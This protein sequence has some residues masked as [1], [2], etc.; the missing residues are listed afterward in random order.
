MEKSSDC[1]NYGLHAAG[2]S[3]SNQGQYKFRTIYHGRNTRIGTRY[4]LRRWDK[5]P[6][7]IWV[8]ISNAGADLLGPFES[9]EAAM[10][11]IKIVGLP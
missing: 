2:W 9:E 6:K 5:S 1:E 4:Q 11:T 3:N 10:I 8:S 7:D